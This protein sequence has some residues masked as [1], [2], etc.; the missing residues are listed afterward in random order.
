M[1]SL[2]RLSQLRGQGIM[3]RREDRGRWRARFARTASAA[4]HVLLAGPPLFH[5]APQSLVAKPGA[6]G[7][8]SER[9]FVTKIKLDGFTKNTRILVRCHGLRTLRKYQLGRRWR[10][11]RTKG[12]APL[13]RLIGMRVRR[14]QSRPVEIPRM[15]M[16]EPRAGAVHDAREHHE[17]HGR[18]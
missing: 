4:D 15:H 11:L 2:L 5:T 17:R 14:G 10:T 12:A 16:S 7:Q 18:G 9:D 13:P 8:H 3:R 6:L 1:S